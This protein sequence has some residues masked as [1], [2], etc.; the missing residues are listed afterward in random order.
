M[1]PDFSRQLIKGKIAE[2]IFEQMFRE[3]GRFT[4]IPFGYETVM[5]ELMQ[6]ARGEAYRDLVDNIRNA[7]DFAMISHNPDEVYLVEVK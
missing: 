4:V 1:Q 3:T 6:Y 7:P 2:V 5:P